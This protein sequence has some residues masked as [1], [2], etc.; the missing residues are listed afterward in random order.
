MKLTI[1]LTAVLLANIGHASIKSES[2]E[3]VKM[4]LWYEGIEQIEEE[5]IVLG[6]KR[7]QELAKREL[8]E[9]L[10]LVLEENM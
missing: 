8:P 6:E 2:L 5:P 7:N 3:E 4:S 1:F 9:E 10:K